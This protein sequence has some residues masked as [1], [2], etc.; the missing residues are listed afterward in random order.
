M[1]PTVRQAPATAI[2]ASSTT[3]TPEIERALPGCRD[4][5]SDLLVPQF[6]VGFL[7][8]RGSMHLPDVH[9]VPGGQR[10]QFDGSHVRAAALELEGDELARRVGAQTPPATCVRSWRVRWCGISSLVESRSTSRRERRLR[11]AWYS[12]TGQVPRARGS[13][14]RDRRD[15]ATSDTRMRRTSPPTPASA[16]RIRRDQRITAPH[17]GDNRQEPVLYRSFRWSCMPSSD[18]DHGS[19]GAFRQNSTD[20]DTPTEGAIRSASSGARKLPP[21]HPGSAFRHPATASLPLACRLGFPHE[22]ACCHFSRS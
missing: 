4:D 15:A 20:P 2:P 6:A 16:T 19:I 17:F 10:R 5:G 14:L 18:V 11:R 8:F 7:R 1:W 21:A 3:P 13:S 12:A 22:P 9:H